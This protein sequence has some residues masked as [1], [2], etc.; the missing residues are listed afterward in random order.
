MKNIVKYELVGDGKGLLAYFADGQFYHVHSDEL[1]SLEK[2][3]RAILVLLKNIRRQD[4][5]CTFYRNRLDAVSIDNK[6]IQLI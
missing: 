5:F 1:D 4:G 3:I 6:K 2:W